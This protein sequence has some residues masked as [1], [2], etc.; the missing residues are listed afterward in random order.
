[1]ELQQASKISSFVPVYA[2]PKNFREPQGVMGDLLRRFNGQTDCTN[3]EIIK[4]G[5]YQSTPPPPIQQIQQA[6]I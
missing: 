2:D 5:M 1:M 4:I 3:K 6:H